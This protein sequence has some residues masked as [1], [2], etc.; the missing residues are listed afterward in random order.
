[1]TKTILACAALLALALPGCGP[2]TE[3]EPAEETAANEAPAPFESAPADEPAVA[4]ESRAVTGEI[5]SV[6][7][8]AKTL[9]LLQSDNTT[10]EYW[11]TETTEIVGAAGTQ[12][13]AG[14]QGSRATIYFDGQS[15]PPIAERIEIM[16]DAAA[17]ATGPAELPEPDPGAAAP[18]EATPETPAP[19]TP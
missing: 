1:M 12:G 16:A 18:G 2:G 14:E 7:L 8:D 5:Q 13:L 4:A 9:T 19:D 3:T 10:M 17:P 11:F 15:D 6:D